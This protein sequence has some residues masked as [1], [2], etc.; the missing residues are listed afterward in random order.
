MNNTYNG[1]PV[2]EAREYAS[3]DAA[4]VQKRRGGLDT[5]RGG[6]DVGEIPMMVGALVESHMRLDREIGLLREKLG[7]VL[8]PDTMV[9]GENS[10]IKAESEIGSRLSDA[11]AHVD[12]LSNVVVELRTRA[13][14]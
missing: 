4:V 12:A 2:E 5:P 10:R 8:A 7:P 9:T 11:I 1:M 14:L 13:R 3:R 6:E